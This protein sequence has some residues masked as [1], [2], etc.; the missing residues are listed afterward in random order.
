MEAKASMQDFL[1]PTF[2]FHREKYET[3]QWFAKFFEP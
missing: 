2:S 1:S 3:Q